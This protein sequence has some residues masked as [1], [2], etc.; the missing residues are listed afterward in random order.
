MSL[1]AQVFPQE[2]YNF[3]QQRDLL[4]AYNETMTLVGGDRLSFLE[5]LYNMFLAFKVDT[6]AL[7]SSSKLNIRPIF[8]AP[9]SY[10]NIN[11]YYA[12]IANRKITI[13]YDNGYVS[14]VTLSDK[15]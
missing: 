13:H 14:Q 10:A 15:N 6:N 9:A 5:W 7:G 11:M 12:S 8:R 2:S 3:N 4:R 1:G